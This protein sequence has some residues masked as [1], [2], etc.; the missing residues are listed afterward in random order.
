MITNTTIFTGGDSKYWKQY[1]KS[2]VKSFKHF[3]PDTDVLI[4][5]FNPDSDDIAELNSLDCK[6]TIENIEQSYI[7]DLVN[8]HIDVYTNNTNPQ[9]KAQLKTGMKFSEKNYGFVTLEDKM[10]HLITFAIYASFRFIRLAE[11]WDGKNPIAAYDMDTVCQGSIDIDEMLGE[12]DA[13][14]LEVKGNRL[15]VSLV[16]FR[17]NN[18]LLSEW[19]NS[20]QQS[21]NNKAVYGFLDQNTFIECASKYTVTSIPRM[22]CDHTKKSHSSKVLTGK[23][24]SKWGS[25][26][27][28]AQSRWLT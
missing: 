18:Q 22:Y 21:F 14:C 5:V 27:Q 23:G 8:A 13:G 17:N 20:L 3:N 7:D 28:L 4:Q 12:N 24:H 25:V 6:Y 2:F 15:V 16:A 11:L 26:F 1:G 19:G 9:L 10:R